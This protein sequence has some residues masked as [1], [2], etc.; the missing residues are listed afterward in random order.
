MFQPHL[1]SCLL[2]LL[3]C[4]PVSALS[5]TTSTEQSAMAAL[6]QQLYFDKNLS[7]NRSQACASC[8]DPAAAFVDP[9]ST[10]PALAGSL[11]ADGHSRGDRQAP[12]AAYAVFSPEFHQNSD[13]D[14]VGGQFWD[15]RA[16]DL[17]E[18]AGGPPLNPGEMAMA[19]QA[20]VLTRLLENPLY[21]ERFPAIFGPQV[22]HQADTAYTALRQSIAAFEQS[23]LF[24]PFDSK[25]DRY[26][27][28]E[29]QPTEQEELGMTLFFSQQFTNCNQCHQLQP[30]AQMAEETF[31]NYRYHNIG[32]P[33]NTALRVNNGVASS[34][35]D[36]GL[37]QNPKLSPAQQAQQAG[38][39]KV[40]SLRNVAVT[41]PYMHN[42]VFADLRTV[43]LFY[44]KYNSKSARRQINP[45]TG[46]PWGP[47]EVAANLALPELEHG[48]AL[49]D[50]RVEA[51][52]A[53]LK[54]LTDQRYEHLLTR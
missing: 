8:H 15:G 54:M 19:D 42:G 52:V 27:R 18:Q 35:Q 26:L 4:L 53:F 9:R 50:K 30:R 7:A 24:S 47:P 6:G 34:S 22:L 36:Q 33:T 20:S 16:Q 5:D 1:Y 28:G 2:A 25:Y 14:Y 41:A 43:V 23:E 44:D 40:P 48:P 37:G 13:G 51:L 29:Y 46:Q 12:M 21:V 49:D 32:V 39:F 45:E 31:T 10:T 38:K 11:G 3:S 17:S